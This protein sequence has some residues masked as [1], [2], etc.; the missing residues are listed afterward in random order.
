MTKEPTDK[1]DYVLVYD[2]ESGLRM[3]PPSARR[4]VFSEPGMIV[5]GQPTPSP[6]VEPLS[7]DWP[8]RRRLT[9]AGFAG[10]CAIGLGL[11]FAARHAPSL[12]SVGALPPSSSRMRVVVASAIPPS[13]PP[14][15]AGA[16]PLEVL[17]RAA[18]V[19]GPTP[20]RA[21]SPAAAQAVIKVDAP[22]AQ[23]TASLDEAVDPCRGARSLGEVVVCRDPGLRA[24]D[25][26]LR[27]AFRAAARSGIP[28]D[29]LRAEQDDWLDIRED[30]AERSPH[31]VARVYDQ[32][33][34]EL[35][36]MVTDGPPE[37]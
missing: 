15:Q 3:A 24:A 29:Q 4:Q 33:I 27:H 37:P 22:A 5:M 25:R 7:N 8:G 6:T 16:L 19:L 11:G 9:L 32:R 13:P 28:Y 30:A 23:A 18:L 20:I 10:L 17:P 14:V 2:G 31:A 34:E 12:P 1:P 21:P 26:R 36:A 35:E